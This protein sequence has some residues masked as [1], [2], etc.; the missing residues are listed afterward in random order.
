MADV[1]GNTHFITRLCKDFF[2][3][4]GQLELPFHD[5]HEFI[6]RMDEIIPLSSGRVGEHVAGIAPLAPV[7]GHLVTIEWHW[8]FLVGETGR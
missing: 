1:F 2:R 4:D 6:R 5:G 8:E 3:T 7:L